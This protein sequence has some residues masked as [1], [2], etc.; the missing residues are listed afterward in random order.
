MTL[1]KCKIK[2][3]NHDPSNGKLLLTV[4]FLAGQP[5]AGDYIYLKEHYVSVHFYKIEKLNKPLLS[6]HYELTIE[7]NEGEWLCKGLIQKHINEQDDTAICGISVEDFNNLNS[8]QKLDYVTK[9]ID[10]TSSGR[11]GAFLKANLKL[12]IK[13]MLKEK[14]GEV[15]LTK[16]G[17]LPIGSSDLYFPKDINGNSAI[18]IC[19]IQL[20]E[21][22]QWFQATKE[23]NGTGVLYFFATIKKRD[24]YPSFDEILVLYSDKI[25]TKQELN[26]PNDI[27]NY[28]VLEEKDLMVAEEVDIPPS[29]TSLWSMN[30]MTKDERNCFSYIEEII[31]QLNVF[32]G[33][34]LLGYPEQIQGCVLFEAELK[35]TKKGWYDPNGLEEGKF[36]E[37]TKE[38]APKAVQWRQLLDIDPSDDYFRKLSNY[39]GEFNKHMDGKF[40]LMIRQEDLEKMDFSKT[41]TIY[42]CT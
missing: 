5:K 27:N 38:L 23:F 30:E 19:Q 8:Q 33:S 25:G 4:D 18:F 31:C 35:S 20:S 10:F 1:S 13:L 17:G 28:G 39:D 42:Q 14:E 26:L 7:F 40:Y 11:F 32:G 41:V 9:L 29:E 12:A 3:L 15:G 16:F 2:D 36:L 21:L 22:N 24:E 6:K 37:L 34:K